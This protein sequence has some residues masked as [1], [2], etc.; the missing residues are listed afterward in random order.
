MPEWVADHHP[1]VVR[2]GD[3]DPA[4]EFRPRVRAAVTVGVLKDEE[5]RLGRDDHAPLVEG[6]PVECIQALGEHRAGVRAAVAIAVLE[7]EDLVRRPF[8]RNR[9]G[10]GGHRHDPEAAAG[11]KAELDRIA[12][13]GE[14]FLGGEEVERV[15]LGDDELRL[16][17]GGSADV[18]AGEAI[19]S[20]LAGG[21]GR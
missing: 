10:E 20:H 17:V 18:T 3:V 7:D 8:A 6:D 4:E 13:F 11:V 5:P 12:Q 9:V 14:L 19:G 15:A 21:E 1:A 2:I 16:E